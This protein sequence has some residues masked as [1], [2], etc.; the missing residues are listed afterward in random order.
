MLLGTEFHLTYKSCTCYSI[1]FQLRKRGFHPWLQPHL[2][3]ALSLG[4]KIR[5]DGG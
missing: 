2:D 5:V 3:G 4:I 1:V